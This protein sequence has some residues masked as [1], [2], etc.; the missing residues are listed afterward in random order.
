MESEFVKEKIRKDIFSNKSFRVI[1]NT[2]FEEELKNLN[3][4]NIVKMFNDVYKLEPNPA[5]YQFSE[6]W[7]EYFKLGNNFLKMLLNKKIL[8][9]TDYDDVNILIMYGNETLHNHEVN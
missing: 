6:F 7:D 4:E 1:N 5:P 3:V 9:T 2:G 8:E